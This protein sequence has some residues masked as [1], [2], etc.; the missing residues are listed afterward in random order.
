M[1][2]EPEHAAAFSREVHVL[3]SDEEAGVWRDQ[4]SFP[5]ESQFE[6]NPCG[7]PHSRAPCLTGDIAADTELGGRP[8]TGQSL[9]QGLLVFRKLAS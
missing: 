7:W 2:S 1:R 9:K 3:L 6:L 8:A 5:A 4:C